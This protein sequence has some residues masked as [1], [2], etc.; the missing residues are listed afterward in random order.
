M[1]CEEANRIRTDTTSDRD[2]RQIM[3]VDILAKRSE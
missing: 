1:H 3:N 2:N